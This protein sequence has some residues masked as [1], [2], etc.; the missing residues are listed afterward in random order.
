[1]TTAGTPALLAAALFS[2]HSNPWLNMHH[3]VRAVARGEPLPVAMAA[4]EKPAWDA[5][6]ALYRERYARRDLLFDE[7]MA[8]I[9]DA[10]RKAGQ[11]ETLAGLG[12]DPAL[13]AA[14][15]RAAPVYR[16]HFWPK[17]DASNRA[18]I[19]AVEPQLRAHGAVLARKVAAAYGQA[20]PSQPMDVDVSV[21]AGPFG[22]YTTSGPPTHIVISS[23]DPAYRIAALEMLFH[24]AS[25]AWDVVVEKGIARAAAAQGRRAPPQLWHAIL[26]FTAGELT[27]REMEL[28]GDEDYVEHALRSGVYTRACGDCRALLA[29]HWGP[30]LDGRATIDEALAAL[31]AAVA[32]SP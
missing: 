5:A 17:H 3:F 8:A 22:A 27:R 13:A 10:L 2:F 21:Q 1:M 19:A 9:K 24:E 7:G 14:L 12:L 16:R 4:D 6:V 30:R 29:K 11:R 32:P 20:W 28:F 31:V 15:E 18:W 25:H 23:V 26:F